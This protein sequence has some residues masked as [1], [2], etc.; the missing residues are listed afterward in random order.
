LNPDLIFLNDINIKGRLFGEWTTRTE[1]TDRIGGWG[2]KYDWSTLYAWINR[3]MKIIEIGKW[4]VWGNKK[5]VEGVNMIK[6]HYTY[7]VYKYHNG[8]FSH[9]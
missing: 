3:I 6:V 8:S 5:R 9:N 7:N 2:H 1:E 4:K